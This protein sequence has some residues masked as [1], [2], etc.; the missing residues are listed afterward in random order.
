[1]D[2][3][4]IE[5]KDLIQRWGIADWELLKRVRHGW[6]EYRFKKKRWLLRPYHRAYGKPFMVNIVQTPPLIK[7]YRSGPPDPLFLEK[8]ED[9]LPILPDCLF[10][11]EDV[12]TVEKLE[13]TL[14]KASINRPNMRKTVVLEVAKWVQKN[15]PNLTKKEAAAEINDRLRTDYNYGGYSEKHLMRLINELGF[16]LGKPGRKLKK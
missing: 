12:S 5:G 2:K 11:R 6:E 15:S 7:Y 16:S 14:C 8:I 13:P 9:I 1:M 10:L 4:F 3:K